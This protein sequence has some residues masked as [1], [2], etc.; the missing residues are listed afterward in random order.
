MKITNILLVGNGFGYTDKREEGIY[1]INKDYIT[2]DELYYYYYHDETNPVDPEEYYY[3][4]THGLRPILTMKSDVEVYSGNG[5]EENPFIITINLKYDDFGETELADNFFEFNEASNTIV[6]I[7]ENVDK[8]FNETGWFYDGYYEN[9]GIKIFSYRGSTLEIPKEI[10]NVLVKTIGLR[11]AGYEDYSNGWTG[12][13]TDFSGKTNER[14]NKSI[15]L[16]IPEGI[17]QILPAAFS[18]CYWI[19]EVELPSTVKEINTRTFYDCG[20]LENI[21]L[22]NK[23]TTIGNTAFALCKKLETI[24]IPSSVTSIGENAFYHCNNL[25]SITI[26][27]GSSLSIDE[28]KWGAPETTEIITK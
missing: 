24:T 7:K 21:K 2:W 23:T 22:G 10:N 25:K 18:N 15:K 17:E 16:F 26:E 8:D 3:Q 14:L 20:N 27:S 1:Y 28:N 9:T 5:T 19:K 4:S 13:K 12:Y 11:E 6:G